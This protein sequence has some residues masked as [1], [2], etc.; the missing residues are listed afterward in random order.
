MNHNL[1][2]GTGKWFE[3]LEEKY[4]LLNQ[5]MNQWMTKGFK[6]QPRLHWCLLFKKKSVCSVYLE[7][8]PD[9][10]LLY[11]HVLCCVVLPKKGLWKHGAGGAAADRSQGIHSVL[12][13]L[14]GKYIIWRAHIFPEI[15][16]RNQYSLIPHMVKL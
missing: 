2:I 10:F 16:F 6:E 7:I 11:L 12:A 4:D 15:N 3:D 9:I 14:V 5:C 8:W 1:W 13:M